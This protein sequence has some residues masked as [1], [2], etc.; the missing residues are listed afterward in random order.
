LISRFVLSP[1]FQWPQSGHLCIIR[2]LT[3]PIFPY[4]CELTIF[5][6]PSYYPTLFQELAGKMTT[7][8]ASIIHML[9]ILWAHISPKGKAALVEIKQASW[10]PQ[11][12][13][14]SGIKSEWFL[15]K[16]YNWEADNSLKFGPE[17]T[18]HLMICGTREENLV[19]IVNLSRYEQDYLLVNPDSESQKYLPGSI[20]PLDLHRIELTSPSVFLYYR[21]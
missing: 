12:P 17:G 20:Q 19:E 2:L 18:S 21:I 8:I 13:S 5:S 1:A 9:F 7:T 6:D 11:I 16:R 10:M 15:E 4:Y 14:R 3:Y